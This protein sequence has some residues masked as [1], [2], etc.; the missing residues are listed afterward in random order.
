MLN[1]L[2]SS[3]KRSQSAMEYL[4]TYGWSIL[5][6]AVVLGALSFL[7]VFNPMT[8]TPKATAGGCQVI[9]NT[10][11][12]IS[13]LEGACNNQ[14]PQYVAQFNGESSYISTGTSDLPLGSN[15]RS[16]FAWIYL[17]GNNL[18]QS[19]FS[20]GSQSSSEEIRLEVFSGNILANIY[21]SG[22]SGLGIQIPEDEW[23]LVGYVYSDSGSSVT[24]YYN[25]QSSTV[26][27][28]TGPPNTILAATDPSDI[29]KEQGISGSYFDGS[30]ANL[31]IYNT[32]LTNSS[33]KTLYDEGIGG[34]P[35]DLQNLVGWWPLNGNANDYSG[36]QNNGVPTNVVFTSNWYVGYTQ[37]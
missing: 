26:P 2:K 29:G 28:N 8:F 33:I 21:G 4:M 15:P 14:V 17:T 9:K 5:I 37:P 10:E 7:G 18:R 31:Q 19:I 27:E 23:I 6:V 3:S 1:D 25:T 13:N 36:N 30:I 16:V 22:E 12:G 24:V 32:S 11:L 20:Y 34:A 35:V